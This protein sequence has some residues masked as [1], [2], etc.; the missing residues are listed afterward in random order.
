MSKKIGIQLDSDGDLFISN[1]SLQIGDTLYQNQYILLS[2]QKGDLKH[3]PTLGVGLSDMLHDDDILGWK[4]AI[5]EDF[6]KDGIKVSKL[7]IT[8]SSITLEADY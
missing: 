8:T 3:V 7:E 5:R 1:G 6:A 4:R 2:A